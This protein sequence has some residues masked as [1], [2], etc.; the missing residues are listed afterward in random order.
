MGWQKGHHGKI[1][2]VILGQDCVQ[3]SDAALDDLYFLKNL[4]YQ[5]QCNY[6]MNLGVAQ[7]RVALSQFF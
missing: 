5:K 7:I 2:G 1:S 3:L 4:F 6:A